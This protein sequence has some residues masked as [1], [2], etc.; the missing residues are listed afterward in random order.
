MRT[1]QV[2]NARLLNSF[3]VSASLHGL[4]AWGAWSIRP[5]TQPPM[6]PLSRGVVCVR[7]R[8]S[9]LIVHGSD[10]GLGEM[11]AVYDRVPWPRTERLRSPDSPEAPPQRTTASREPPLPLL[12]TRD[13][14]R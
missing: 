12:E 11:K 13:L 7:V 8:S 10:D 9:P 5:A 4:L 14:L 1:R 3:M 2:M 6:L